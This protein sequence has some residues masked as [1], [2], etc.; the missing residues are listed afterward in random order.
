[1]KRSQLISAFEKK[2]G[3]SSNKFDAE[4]WRECDGFIDGY[5]L[6]Q[7]ELEKAYRYGEQGRTYCMKDGTAI[8]PSSY[9][10]VDG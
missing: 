9:E 2:K 4:E 6:A 8:L 10:G 5:L 1:M 7:E 3:Y